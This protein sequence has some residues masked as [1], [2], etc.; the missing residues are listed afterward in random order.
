MKFSHL[1]IGVLTGFSNTDLDVSGYMHWWGYVHHQLQKKKR[2]KKKRPTSLNRIVTEQLL[3][4]LHQINPPN[5]YMALHA[6]HWCSR[7]ST[8]PEA[9]NIIPLPTANLLHMTSEAPQSGFS[10]S[11]KPWSQGLPEIEELQDRFVFWKV[12]NS[13]LV[14]QK[15]EG[16]WFPHH[17]LSYKRHNFTR[18]GSL[19]HLGPG[20]KKEFQGMLHRITQSG[21]R[22]SILGLP[23]FKACKVSSV[24]VNGRITNSGVLHIPTSPMYAP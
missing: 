12:M 4:S 18:N 3:S 15:T 23:L 22:L 19:V 13:K 1:V 11:H 10:R 6:W 14:I 21:R 24:V 8:F 16:F 5:N 9:W 7:K 20:S 2:E 17:H